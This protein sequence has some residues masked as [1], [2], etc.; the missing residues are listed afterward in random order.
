[1]KTTELKPGQI[2][3]I[4]QFETSKNCYLT[5]SDISIMDKDFRLEYS[6][7]QNAIAAFKIKSVRGLPV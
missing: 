5:G 6:K 7:S 1:M 2:F 3:N 4:Y